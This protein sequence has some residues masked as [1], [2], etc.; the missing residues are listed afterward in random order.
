LFTPSFNQ[1][2]FIE[3]TIQSVLNQDYPNIEYLV[4]DG[5]S[6]DNTLE[7]LRKYEGR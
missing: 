3:E 2:H 1:G 4:L 7:I 5:G 6:T